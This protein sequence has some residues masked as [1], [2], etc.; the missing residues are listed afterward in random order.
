[1]E[2]ESSGSFL[3]PKKNTPSA[4]AIQMSCGPSIAF[5]L[6]LAR[7]SAVPSPRLGRGTRGKCSD[8]RQANERKNHGKPRPHAHSILPRRGGQVIATHGL[9]ANAV[10]AV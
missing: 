6:R 7:A 9:R 5:L 10:P 2:R 8:N 3:A 4:S 1:M